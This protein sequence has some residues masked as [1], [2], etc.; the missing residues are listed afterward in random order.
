M[1][2]PNR[3]PILT[4]QGT[5]KPTEF[6]FRSQADPIFEKLEAENQRLR[7]LIS[8]I[9]YYA[10]TELYGEDDHIRDLW[11]RIREALGPK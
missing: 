3:P 2:A 4:R 10:P 9:S 7:D 5:F 11:V 1:S 8:D 6:Y